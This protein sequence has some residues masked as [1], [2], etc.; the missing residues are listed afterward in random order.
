M[1]QPR[2]TLEH[3]SSIPSIRDAIKH[4]VAAV[5][6]YIHRTQHYL[7]YC[8]KCDATNRSKNNL[9]FSNDEC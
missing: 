7:T 6:V 3:A 1:L 8:R 4:P 2:K 9:F 5:G